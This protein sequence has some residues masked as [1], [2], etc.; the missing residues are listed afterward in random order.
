[1]TGGLDRG[2]S[3]GFMSFEENVSDLVKNVASLGH[4]L[5]CLIAHKKIVT[6]YVHLERSEI[7]ET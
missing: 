1:V 3:S 7:E 4:D 5:E 2:E 6:D